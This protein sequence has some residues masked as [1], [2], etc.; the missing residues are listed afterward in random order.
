MRYGQQIRFIHFEAYFYKAT[1]FVHPTPSIS[2]LYLNLLPI[3]FLNGNTF[4]NLLFSFQ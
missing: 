1:Y 2:S 3:A 4:S